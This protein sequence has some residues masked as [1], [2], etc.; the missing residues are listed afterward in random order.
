MTGYTA[1][2]GAQTYNTMSTF[3]EDRI[4]ALVSQLSKEGKR[5][6]KECER[7]AEYTH[8]SMNLKDSYGYGIYVRGVLRK[9]GFLGSAE[10]EGGKRW[11]GE[12][13]EGREQIENFLTKEYRPTNGIELV[14]AAAMPY[15]EVLENA[16]SGQHRKYRVVSMSY[17]KLKELSANIGGSTVSTILRSERG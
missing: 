2:Y 11:Y 15:G 5:I 13:I 16:S 14:I 10:A 3:Y 1:L 17:D 7:E 6:L 12:T 9:K 8:R 4:N